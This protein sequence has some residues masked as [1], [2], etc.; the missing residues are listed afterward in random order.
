MM[1]NLVLL[2]IENSSKQSQNDIVCAIENS[3]E[4]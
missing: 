4:R 3:I 2:N 1:T